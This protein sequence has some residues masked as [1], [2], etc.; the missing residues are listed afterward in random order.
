MNN[1]IAYVKNQVLPSIMAY[2]DGNYIGESIY[3]K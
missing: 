2:Y 3:T 1:V